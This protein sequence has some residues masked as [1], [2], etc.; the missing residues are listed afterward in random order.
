M[1]S[2]HPPVREGPY[3]RQGVFRSQPGNPRPLSINPSSDYHIAD[4]LVDGVTVGSV[5]SYPFTDVQSNHDI[6]ASFSPDSGSFYINSIPSKAVIY[7]DDNEV[8]TTPGLVKDVTP[9]THT[10]RLYMIGYEEWSTQVTIQLR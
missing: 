2:K 6:Q 3:P 1:L 10:I 8:G 7:L 5:S 4:V 9:G